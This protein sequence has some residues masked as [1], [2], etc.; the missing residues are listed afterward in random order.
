MG[1][2][3]RETEGAVDPVEVKARRRK[4]AA[5]T[6]TW[7]ERFLSQSLRT[8]FELK[9]TR[10]MLEMLCATS[11]DVIWDRA[12]FGNM[13]SPDNWIVTE[14]ALAKRGLLVRKEPKAVK[15]KM[16][17]QGWSPTSFYE[18][19]PAGVALVELLK[20]GGLYLP[21]QEALERLAGRKGR[22]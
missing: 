6:G 10:P 2:S 3:G 9:L 5:T 15:F 4:A 11:D 22:L 19:T 1:E 8:H 12:R 18:L 17:A 21:A 7:R 16:G 14:T 20:V 13:F